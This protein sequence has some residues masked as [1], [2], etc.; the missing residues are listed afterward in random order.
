MDFQECCITPPIE[1][2]H[3]FWRVVCKKIFFKAKWP[4]V[5]LPFEMGSATM[6][7]KGKERI[8]ALHITTKVE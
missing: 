4:V 5:L 7:E 3:K 1:R 6:N 8:G 2:P